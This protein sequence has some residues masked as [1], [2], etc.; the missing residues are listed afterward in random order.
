MIV[1]EC[2]VYLL[3][4]SFGLSLQYVWIAFVCEREKERRG[5]MWFTD[6]KILALGKDLVG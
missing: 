3:T 1:K 5:R 6:F 2:A 4:E